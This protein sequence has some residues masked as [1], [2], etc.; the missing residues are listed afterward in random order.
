VNVRVRL[1]SEVFIDPFEDPYRRAQQPPLDIEA[2][3]ATVPNDDIFVAISSVVP[4]L[5]SRVALPIHV[6]YGVPAQIPYAA[7]E[8]HP[9]SMSLNCRS[10]DTASFPPQ[11]ELLNTTIPVGILSHQAFVDIGLLLLLAV[12]S[13]GFLRLMMARNITQQHHPKALQSN[14]IGTFLQDTTYITSSYHF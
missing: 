1:S 10:S 6:R 3:T 8:I 13:I 9:P 11:T 2:S 14:D 12:P 5:T 7:V 4:D